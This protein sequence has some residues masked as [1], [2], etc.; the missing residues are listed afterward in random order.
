MGPPEG[1]K[2]GTL[3]ETAADGRYWGRQS[4]FS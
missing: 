1:G 2:A 3:G 4:M